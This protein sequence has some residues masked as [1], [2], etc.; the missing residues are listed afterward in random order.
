MQ[1]EGGLQ[2]VASRQVGTDINEGWISAL[3]Q[4]CL[5]PGCG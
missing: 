1:G 3:A 2:A 4:T 5:A